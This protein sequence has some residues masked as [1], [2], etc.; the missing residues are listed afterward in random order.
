MTAT[1]TAGQ[2]WLRTF[3]PAPDAPVRLACFP[4]AG[5]AA[6]LF[7]GLA[8]DL[9]RSADAELVAVQ[10][11]GR[12][13]RRAEP[14]ATDLG[15]LADHAADGLAAA[16]PRPLVLFG[17]SMGALVAFETAERLHARGVPLAGLIVSG[18]RAPHL[19]RP[20]RVHT[21]SDE[22]LVASLRELGGTHDGLLADE[23]FLRL[24]LPAVRGDYQAVETYRRALSPARLTCPVLAV[25]GDDDP[26]VTAEEAGQWAL[27]T[28]GAFEQR[29][30]P[31]GHFTLV[32][33]RA[34]LGALLREGIGA[35][36]REGLGALRVP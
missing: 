31:G 28:R 18:R 9:A 22:G 32:Q 6:G 7:R 14:V 12:Q 30:V 33:D 3:H 8:R 16:D 1:R 35:V 2:D 17:H 23:R 25:V 19:N 4:H 27:H 34:G 10:Y 11:P 5:G 15:V 29:T 26:L 36:L 24:I 21:R 20:G 13:D